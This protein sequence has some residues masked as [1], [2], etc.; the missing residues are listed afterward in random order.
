[1]YCTQ[2]G[3][4]A[5]EPIRPAQSSPP[6]DAT[7]P[8][9]PHEFQPQRMT[10]QRMQPWGI[11]SSGSP[12]RIPTPIFLL[13][14]IAQIVGILIFLVK[15]VL[16]RNDWVSNFWFQA[17]IP[18]A[19]GDLLLV[20]PI[21]ALGFSRKTAESP[22]L[23]MAAVVAGFLQFA[24][25]A[26]AIASNG[27][28]F[29]AY[30]FEG[31]VA[32]ST[33]FL[34]SSILAAC[35]LAVIPLAVIQMQLGHWILRPKK[36]WWRV[37]FGPIAILFLMI[38]QPQRVV[39]ERWTLLSVLLILML[40]FSGLLVNRLAAGAFFGLVIAIGGSLFSYLAYWILSSDESFSA[41]SLPSA[42]AML[43]A[44][45]GV[46][47]TAKGSTTLHRQISNLGGTK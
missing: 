34:P 19:I 29:D 41:V 27:F 26:P 12:P 7:T 38:E 8:T 46:I 13:L 25:A 42:A 3:K 37:V 18:F 36:E 28:N 24:R 21:I 35:G 20:S 31:I 14:G 4:R 17:A 6:F 39:S 11:P 45:A 10:P 22:A 33:I 47:S 40:A 30:F 5:V 16:D 15:V 32:S 1:M 23:L 2:C 9:L 44:I 43:V